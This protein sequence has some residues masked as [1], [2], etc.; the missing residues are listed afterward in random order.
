MSKTDIIEDC[1]K[2]IDNKFDLVVYA[3]QISIDEYYKNDLNKN[4][5]PI[6]IALNKIAT[7][8]F[9]EAKIKKAIRNRFI[10]NRNHLSEEISDSEETSTKEEEITFE[11][12]ISEEVM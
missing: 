3:A 12:F 7:Q 6:D 4:A 5:N 9:N 10:R 11:D 8:N 1:L 2:V